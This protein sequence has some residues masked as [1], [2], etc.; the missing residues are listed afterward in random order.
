[1]I[2]LFQR[3][4]AGLS[5]EPGL[6]VLEQAESL[7]QAG[8]GRIAEKIAKIAKQNRCAHVWGNAWSQATAFKSLSERAK[9]TV[10]F[11]IHQV[12]TDAQLS[13]IPSSQ[14]QDMGYGWNNTAH[15]PGY[16]HNQNF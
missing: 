9:A 4:Q 14:Q 3:S 10:K 6:P 11:K 16:N 13:D 15:Y 5:P 1:M 8:T 2:Y 7:E 12:I